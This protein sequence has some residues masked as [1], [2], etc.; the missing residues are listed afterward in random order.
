MPILTMLDGF[1]HSTL[2]ASL[3]CPYVMIQQ[4]S[5]VKAG[6]CVQNSCPEICLACRENLP[7]FESL[8]ITLEGL[9]EQ[10]RR[11]A[12]EQDMVNSHKLSKQYLKDTGG[13]GGSLI[14]LQG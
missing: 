1:E 11:L 8:P 10:G 13:G 6:S 2:S 7:T 4:D 9:L 5:R 12:R 3:P 14:G